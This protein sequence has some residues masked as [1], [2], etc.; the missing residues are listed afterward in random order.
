MPG[1]IVAEEMIIVGKDTLV[2]GASSSTQFAVVFE[3]NGETGYFYACDMSRESSVVDAMQIYNVNNVTDKYLPS[4]VVIAWS[5]DGL[6]AGL[7]I[8]RYPHAVFDFTS[9]RGYCRTN[10]PPPSKEWSAFHEDHEWDE[11]AIELIK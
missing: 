10:F 4:Q 8:N 2:E 11:N 3:D 1:Y 5:E 9:K 6:K 7:F